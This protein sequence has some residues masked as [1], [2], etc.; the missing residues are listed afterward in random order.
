MAFALDATTNFSGSII[1]VFTVEPIVNGSGHSGG[2][3][4]EMAF[5]RA[6]S[7]RISSKPTEGTGSDVSYS[8]TSNAANRSMSISVANPVPIGAAAIAAFAGNT[9]YGAQI[10]QN[11]NLIVAASK[12]GSSA[13]SSIPLGNFTVSVWI[14]GGTTPLPAGDYTVSVTTTLLAN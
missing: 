5:T 2:S 8:M 12:G 9:Q 1:D 4:G 10:H 11:G 7:T 14:D 6:S 13:P 3:G